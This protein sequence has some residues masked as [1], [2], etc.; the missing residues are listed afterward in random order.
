M[1]C[2]YLKDPAACPGPSNM[3][4]R[5]NSASRVCV[6]AGTGERCDSTISMWLARAEADGFDMLQPVT[7]MVAENHLDTSTTIYF[8][9]GESSQK[10]QSSHKTQQSSWK[11]MLQLNPELGNDFLQQAFL[12]RGK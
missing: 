2:H 3:S 4:P 1:D 9:F 12:G 6:L 5:E 11:L 10:F 7:L 8:G